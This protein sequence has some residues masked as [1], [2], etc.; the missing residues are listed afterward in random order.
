MHN[1]AVMESPCPHCNGTGKINA[2]AQLVPVKQYVPVTNMLQALKAKIGIDAFVDSAMER[3]FG[4][5][6]INLMEKIGKE[7]MAYR[8]TVILSDP[9]HHK[10]S[11]RIKYL[12]N[13]VKGFIQPLSVVLNLNDIPASLQRPSVPYR[14]HIAFKDGTYINVNSVAGQAV[15]DSIGKHYQSFTYGGETFSFNSISKITRSK[16]LENETLPP[17]PETPVNYERLHSIREELK[18]KFTT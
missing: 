12:Y 1:K 10:N 13:Q 8:L 14:Y 6:F 5:H 4:R 11:N 18:R 15:N 7:Q 16:T 17:P 9:F 3:N 2:E